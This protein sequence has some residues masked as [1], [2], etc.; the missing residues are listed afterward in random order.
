VVLG[1]LPDGDGG[2][3]GFFPRTSNDTWCGSYRETAKKIEER[4]SGSD[5]FELGGSWYG[6]RGDGEH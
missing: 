1:G 4:K 3:P 5:N 2:L 6:H